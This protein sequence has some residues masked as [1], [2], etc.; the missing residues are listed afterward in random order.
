[1]SF[2]KVLVGF[3]AVIYTLSAFTFGESSVSLFFFLTGIA[4]TPSSSGMFSFLLI[5]WIV[6]A[7]FLKPKSWVVFAVVYLLLGLSGFFM[8][9]SHYY[10]AGVYPLINSLTLMT[11]LIF[12]FFQLRF[13]SK[14]KTK[15]S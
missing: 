1:M 14:K 7:S 9:P 6:I 11:Y 10:G 5:T 12:V 3:F 13:S 4:D 8:P 2:N 15:E